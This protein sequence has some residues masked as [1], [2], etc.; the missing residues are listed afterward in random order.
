MDFLGRPHNLFFVNENEVKRT[1]HL[2]GC[3]VVN[4]KNMPIQKKFL[5]SK[6]SGLHV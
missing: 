1:V 3:T 6:K 5:A 2:T 4:T